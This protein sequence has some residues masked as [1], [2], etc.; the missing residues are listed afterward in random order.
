MA[1]RRI[2]SPGFFYFPMNMDI[3]LSDLSGV[4]VIPVVLLFL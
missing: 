4:S 1:W 2:R 3:I